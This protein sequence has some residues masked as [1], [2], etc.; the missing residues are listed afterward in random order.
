MRKQTII[1]LILPLLLIFTT[2]SAYGYSADYSEKF[3]YTGQYY[4]TWYLYS[5]FRD[6]SNNQLYPGVTSKYNNPRPL[7]SS[8]HGGVDFS[9][10]TGTNVYPLAHSVVEYI[11]TSID[12]NFGKFV[13]VRYDVNQ[14]GYTDAVYGRHAH[15]TVDKVNVGSFFM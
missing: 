9:A 11:N 13:I 1:S 12:P 6:S 8:P 5:P 14:D 4:G 15:Q 10:K 3:R 2:V 7:S